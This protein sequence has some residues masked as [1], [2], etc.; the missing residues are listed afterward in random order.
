LERHSE[1]VES[2]QFSNHLPYTASAG[3]D[4]NVHVWNMTSNTKRYTVSHEEAVTKLMW[5]PDGN[6]LVT[7]SLDGLIKVWDS[8]TGD[9]L[10]TFHGHMNSVLDFDIQADGAYIVSG[11]DDGNC[12][13]FALS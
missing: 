4:G 2:V 13:V 3:V 9:L 7:S 1:S 6:K 10:K 12:L 5:S 8:R 11:S